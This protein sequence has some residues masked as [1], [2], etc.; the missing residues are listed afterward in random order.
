MLHFNLSS[1]AGRK[2]H[3]E[4]LRSDSL[5]RIRTKMCFFVDLSQLQDFVPTLAKTAHVNSRLLFTKKKNLPE[6][7]G[8]VPR[9]PPL[10]TPLSD[11]TLR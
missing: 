2:I 8:R 3:V 1:I 11:E 7:E 6:K 10:G 5:R 9:V 4:V